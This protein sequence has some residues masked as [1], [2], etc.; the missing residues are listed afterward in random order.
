M[1]IYRILCSFLIKNNYEFSELERE[2]CS[3]DSSDVVFD[4]ELLIPYLNNNY[5]RINVKELDILGVFQELYVCGFMLNERLY[6]PIT[7]YFFDGKYLYLN[8]NLKILQL[9]VKEYF[10]E[11]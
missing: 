10:N 8:Y 5:K 1:D 2:K 3:K 6:N 7:S 9:F 11:K 4:I